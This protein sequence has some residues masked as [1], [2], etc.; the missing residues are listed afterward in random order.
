MSEQLL[1]IEIGGTKLQLALG[2]ASGRIAERA[3]LAVDPAMNADDIKRGIAGVIGSWSSKPSL[4]AVGVGFGGPVDRERGRIACSF[5]VNGWSDFP[6]GSWLHELTGAPVLIENDANAAA[7]AEAALGAG[8]GANPVFYT[9]QGT[10]VGGG[11]VVDGKIYHGVAPGEAEFGH[12]RLDRD[13]ASVQDNCSGRALDGR[14]RVAAT[15]RPGGKLAELLRATK[16]NEAKMLSAALNEGDA[17][18]RAIMLAAAADLAF[19]LSHVVHL[20]H[21]ETIVLGGGLS[22]VGEPWRA[23]VAAALPR[24]IMSAFA[25]G[26]EVKLAE[27]GEDVVLLG[28]LLLAGQRSREKKAV[29]IRP[30]LT[31]WLSE[32]VSAQKR[33]LDTLPLA[34]I[35][36]LVRLLHSALEN[37][38]QIFVFGNGGSAANASHFA[39]DLGKGASDKLGRRFRVISLNDN[40][41]WLTALGNDYAYDDVFVRQLENYADSGDIALTMSVSGDS[42]NCV[43]ALGW[44]KDHGLRTIA[45]VGRKRGRLA[46]IAEH[47][48]TVESE[49]YGRTEDSHMG[50]CHMLCYAF[51]EQAQ[52]VEDG[53]RAR[54][55]STLLSS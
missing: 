42:P 32:Y 38:R 26:P 36:S 43:K 15:N 23:A 12:V 31:P 16:V 49:H 35:E 39:T 48:L 45:L 17:E 25:P 14:L 2:D 27:L 55:L 54:N 52:S 44:A 34:Q 6:L 4:A 46:E 11:L 51:M 37:D 7:L 47:V 33:A 30:A 53:T 19:G 24:N 28:A 21:P 1:A 13:G 22:L 20:F 41:S 50:I 9:N 10:G 18:A 3:R 5:H 29:Q 8:R 40:A